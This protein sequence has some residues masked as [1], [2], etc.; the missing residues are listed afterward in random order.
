MIRIGE[1]AKRSGVSSEVLRA[2]ERRYGVI[3]PGRSEG[4]F[5]LYGDDDVA[6]IRR[7]RTLIDEGMSPAEAARAI[8]GGSAGGLAGDRPLPVELA[9]T[10]ERAL[11][12]LDATTAHDTIDALLGA[13]TIETFL[14]DVA[15]P[16]LRRIGERWAGGGTTVAHEHFATNLMRGRL[17]GLAQGWDRVPG[18]SA[19][20]ACAP[21][22][23]HDIG[24]IALGLALYRHGWRVCYL[25]ANMPI[26]SLSAVAL[27]EHVD[28]VVVSSLDAALFAAATR[29][30]RALGRRVALALGGAGATADIAKKAYARL[31]PN[32]PIAAARELSA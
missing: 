5:R 13:V 32:D 12:A 17:L 28:L 2:W 26:D 22:E 10:L 23:L 25:G 16:V 21:G 11:L 20:L 8:R 29:D 30:L 6:R 19:L 24:L 7:M 18:R 31:L 4:G 3:H 1:L 9:D 27:S 14:R 15:L